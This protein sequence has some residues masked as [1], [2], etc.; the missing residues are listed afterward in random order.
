M[1]K[2]SRRSFLSKALTIGSAAILPFAIHKA[3]GQV[4]EETRELPSL[5]GRKLLFIYGGWP[6][7]EPEKFKDYLVPWL[8]EAGAEV[9]VYNKLDPYTD[10]A[11]M[12]TIDLVIQVMTMSQISREQ[13]KG[14]LDAIRNNGTAM[15]GW[16]G[17][18]CDAFRNN[19]DYQFMTG[20]QWVAHPGGVIDYTVKIVG[21]KDEVTRGLKGFAMHSEQY[22]MHVD[23]NVKVLATTQFS[24]VNDA[25]IDGAIMPVTWKKMYGKG[26]IF[27][28]SLGHNLDHLSKVPDAMEMLKRGIRWASA[29]KYLPA[30]KWLSPVYGK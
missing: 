24:G 3:T 28:T 4:S 23:P 15:A 21:H 9:L 29:S 2:D 17:G 25:W 6:G 8:E 5:K 22:Y 30:E 10:K 26:R 11:L 7:H 13:E 20:G 18:M 14:L 19:P 1:N 12:D 16:H 27:Y